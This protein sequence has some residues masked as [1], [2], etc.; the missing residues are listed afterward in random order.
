MSYLRWGAEGNVRELEQRYIIRI[1]IWK[2]DGLI[3]EANDAFLVMVGRDRE[4]LLAG[5]LDWRA[6]TPPEWL[7]RDDQLLVPELRMS[8]SI[9]PFEKEFYRKDG[10]RVPRH[11]DL[12]YIRTSG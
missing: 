12:R 4:A 11:T 8:G 1:F 10:S 7:S 5:H 6:L 9:H 3:L 2:F